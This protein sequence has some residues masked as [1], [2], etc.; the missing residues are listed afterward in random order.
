MLSGCFFYV[1]DTTPSTPPRY[2]ITFCNES[3]DDVCDWYVKNSSGD[4]FYISESFN[5]VTD[6]STSK[7]RDLKKGDYKVYYSFLPDSYY[8]SSYVKLDEDVKFVLT[9][10]TAYTFRSN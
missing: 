3:G 7:L 2:A 4:K 9:S 1:E 10:K 6:G 5:I 8:E